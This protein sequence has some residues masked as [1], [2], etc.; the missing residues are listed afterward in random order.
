M[1]FV[2]N[3][4]AMSLYTSFQDAV[5]W[6]E[7]IWT[8]SIVGS[9]YLSFIKFDPFAKGAVHSNYRLSQP[10]KNPFHTSFFKVYG[11]LRAPLA[12]SWISAYSVSP[13]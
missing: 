8:P 5:Q 12:K 7:N 3:V 1:V 10:V 9:I 2:R 6:T 4:Y 13:A 11:A